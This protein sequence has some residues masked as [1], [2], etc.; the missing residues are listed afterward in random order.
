MPKTMKGI[1]SIK[2]GNIAADGG[3]AADEDLIE[4]GTTA[5]GSVNMT[6]SDPTFNDILIEE[7]TQPFDTVVTDGTTQITWSTYNLDPTNL[8]RLF[9]G[10]V[11]GNVWKAPSSYINIE[12]SIRITTKNAGVVNVIRALITSRLNLNLTTDRIGQID[13]TAK[14]LAPN[15]ADTEPYNFDFPV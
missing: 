13:I 10:T 7:Q 8:Q 15:K 11:V 6:T 5:K 4:I 1:T 2:L 3:M 12:K 9:G 14:V